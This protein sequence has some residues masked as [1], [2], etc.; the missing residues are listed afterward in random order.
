[1]ITFTRGGT[2]ITMPSTKFGESLG[3]QRPS[4]LAKDGDNIGYR[5]HDPDW[6]TTI[7]DTFT[8]EIPLC[9][10]ST[11]DTY[12]D[13]MD[14]LTDNN[15]QLITVVKDE[16]EDYQSMVGFVAIQGCVE[17]ARYYEATFV[18]SEVS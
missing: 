18:V 7:I 16:P 3:Y 17:H 9:E 10:G 12:G 5:Y 4:K 6:G 13:L 2:T 15:G 11:Y 14:F 1:M 8:V